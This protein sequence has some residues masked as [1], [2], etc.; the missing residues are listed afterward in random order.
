MFSVESTKV[1]KKNKRE[2]RYVM[3]LSIFERRMLNEVFHLCSV[4]KK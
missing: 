3:K 4:K 2:A 1:R